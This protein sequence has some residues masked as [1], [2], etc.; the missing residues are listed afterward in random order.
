MK[1]LVQEGR[2]LALRLHKVRGEGRAAGGVKENELGDVAHLDFGVGEF[3][4][5]A[6]L[7]GAVFDNEVPAKSTLGDEMVVE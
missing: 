3:D 2:I 1:R 6:W 7:V 4:E 5:A